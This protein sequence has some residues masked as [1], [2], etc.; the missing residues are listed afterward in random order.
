MKYT[1][2]LM[3]PYCTWEGV[4]ADS[5]D[6]AIKKCDI[7]PEMDGNERCTFVADEEDEEDEEDK[8]DTIV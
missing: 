8:K 1:V 7:P 5:E 3:T 2:H 6:E 4:E